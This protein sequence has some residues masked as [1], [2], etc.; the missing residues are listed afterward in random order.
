MALTTF[1]MVFLIGSFAGFFGALVGGAGFITIP[2]LIFFGLTPQVAVATNKLGTIGNSFGAIPK[3]WKEKQIIWKYMI[4]LSVISLIGAYIGVNI[5]LNISQDIL[6]KSVGIIILLLLPLVMFSKQLGL[7]NKET[8]KYFKL[9]G[10]VLYVPLMIYGGFM[11]AGGGTLSMYLLMIF[12]GLTFIQSK[13]TEMIPWFFMAIFSL[14]LFAMNGLVN[15]AYGFALLL[16]TLLGGYIGARTAIKKG[17]IW[18]KALFII[19]SSA[20]A[21]KL[22]LF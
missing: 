13:A 18:V 15:Y 22:I 20:A 6:S 12:F 1:L 8:T 9:M 5:V 14:I 17:N 7:K 3:F 11:G 2:F 19:I 21:L 16:G 10:Y 4:P